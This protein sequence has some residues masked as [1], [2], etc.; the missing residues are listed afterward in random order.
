M[1]VSNLYY[2]NQVVKGWI[3]LDCVCHFFVVAIHD[4]SIF[5]M[6]CGLIEWWVFEDCVFVWQLLDLIIV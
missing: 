6:S 1:V 4:V 2:K 5:N 3:G